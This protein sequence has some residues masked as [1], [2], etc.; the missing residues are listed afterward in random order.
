MR[1]QRFLDPLI[2]KKSVGS[3]GRL[4]I[5]VIGFQQFWVVLR[6]KLRQAECLMK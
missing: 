5:P 1:F 2:R 6:E 3:V 4:G